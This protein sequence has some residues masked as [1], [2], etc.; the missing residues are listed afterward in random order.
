MQVTNDYRKRMV[1]EM[2]ETLKEHPAYSTIQFSLIKEAV[3]NCEQKIFIN[4]KNRQEY[5]IAINNKI[6]QIKQ[7][8]INEHEKPMHNNIPIKKNVEKFSYEMPQK[9]MRDLEHNKRK[10]SENKI[11]DLY[12]DKC[13][14]EKHIESNKK[15]KEKTYSFLSDF[16]DF[17]SGVT[18]N[19]NDCLFNLD[20]HKSQR[21]KGM[22]IINK[23]AKIDEE[24]EKATKRQKKHEK[25][26]LIVDEIE[27]EQS[28]LFQNT[29]QIVDIGKEVPKN[30]KFS[31]NI[32]KQEDAKEIAQESSKE[33]NSRKECVKSEINENASTKNKTAF[34]LYIEQNGLKEVDVEDKEE[35]LESL[36]FLMQLGEKTEK[37]VIQNQNKNFIFIGM[38]ELNDRIEWY[39]S[40]LDNFMKDA[41]NAFEKSNKC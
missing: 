27:T 39:S 18:S 6:E 35:W 11:V 17:F 3:L 19:K 23:K 25:R 29:S 16:E 8:N 14:S 28:N 34:E 41:A 24:N 2:M 26:N 31:I 33:P 37:Y 1:L 4:S 22:V 15:Q 13:I 7:T 38:D 30:V 21:K 9:Y 10:E 5:V 40:N 32:S 12:K 20:K 36:D